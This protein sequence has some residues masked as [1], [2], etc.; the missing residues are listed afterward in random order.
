V[1]EAGT[2]INFP[3]THS[4][5]CPLYRLGTLLPLF[6]PLAALLVRRE[7]KPTHKKIKN[8]S[9]NHTKLLT[10]DRIPLFSVVSHHQQT[11]NTTTTKSKKEKKTNK[12]TP[13]ENQAKQLQQQ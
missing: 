11:D 5:S 1:W 3:T 13:K 10:P 6:C 12:K 2:C 8:K 7:S 9:S 4:V